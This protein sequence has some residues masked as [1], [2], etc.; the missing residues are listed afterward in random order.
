MKKAEDRVLWRSMGEVIYCT[1]I[2]RPCV[3]SEGRRVDGSCNN[4]RHASRGA[5]Y[6]PFYRLLPA[7]FRD[8]SKPRLSKSGKPL[9]LA[10]P[11]RTTVLADG[12]VASQNFTALLTTYLVF[13]SADTAI[14]NESVIFATVKPYCCKPEGRRD[15][16]CAPNP[17]PE[18]DP[19]HR[20]SNVRCMNMTKSLTYQYQGCLCNNTTPQ[21]VTSS[22]ATF[23]LSHL[24]GNTDE[25]VEKVRLFKDG[26]LKYEVDAK[27]R[28][29]PPSNK[30][31]PFCP[32]NV[33]PYETR[34]HDTPEAFTSNSLIPLNLMTVWF[35]R[36]H[37][38]IATKLAAINPKW[39][40]E[41]LFYTTRDIV[42]ATYMQIYY[43]ELMAV[44]LG[45][46]NLIK[47]KVLSP[48][49]SFRDIY[50][51]EQFPQSSVEFP[52]ALRWGHTLVEM[53]LNL[54]ETNGVKVKEV[55]LA[56]LSQRTG[57]L[58]VGRNME[59]LTQHIFRQASGDT[60]HIVDPQMGEDAVL[61]LESVDVPTNDVSQN[62]YYGL[63]PYVAYLQYCRGRN[64]ST[65]SD[66][67]DVMDPQRIEIL[68]RI[69]DHPSDV[70]VQAGIWSENYIEGGFAPHTYFCFVV[71][72]MYQTVVSDRHW[73]ERK[74]RPNAFSEVQL[75]EIRKT[76]V[77]RLLC[78]NGD[79]VTEIQPRAFERIQSG[80]ELV[81]CEEIPFVN[82]DAWKD[83]DDYCS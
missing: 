30:N 25:Q 37:N 44:L 59:M 18:D 77:A 79:S 20:F 65:W 13:M 58:G 48:D 38:R 66:L 71:Q 42:I 64:Y 62:R 72:Q 83:T 56:R 8:V 47:R 57:Y 82:L 7:V 54:F 51:E 78:D 12:K 6:T 11:I 5:Q 32:A 74:N 14:S 41:R 61:S 53:T 3:P 81:N 50:D 2:V 29:W 75:K 55:P 24:Y 67:E 21:R 31:S 36:E 22:T 70:D 46:D 52:V 63:A 40:D 80:N 4:L 9:P 27:G 39:D 34:C 16:L 45:R 17:V 19:V 76:S 35:Y 26:L 15:S 69:Y 73:Y 33:P 43:Y 68:Q 1:N 10:R 28:I 60:D 49:P 23:D